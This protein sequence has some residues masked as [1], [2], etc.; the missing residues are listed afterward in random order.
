MHIIRLS[1]PKERQFHLEKKLEI[2]LIHYTGV[3]DADVEGNLI[4]A[5]QRR[6]LTLKSESKVSDFDGGRKRGHLIACARR[7]N[8]QKQFAV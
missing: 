1:H 6:Q 2:E 8:I 4:S 5:A 7:M 3:C